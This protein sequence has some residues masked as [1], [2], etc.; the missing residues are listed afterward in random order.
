MH[1]HHR[2]APLSASPLKRL[3]GYLVEAGLLTH[4]QVSVILNDQQATGM[5]FG[6][7]VVAR[8]WLKEQT[9][10]WIVAK[11][12]EPERRLLRQAVSAAHGFHTAPHSYSE[13]NLG[14]TAS[15]PASQNSASKAAIGQSGQERSGTV[16]PSTPP[17]FVRREAPIS[18]PLPSVG[19]ADGDVNWVG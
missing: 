11:V 4:D 2:Q 5:R 18:K 3:G 15:N 19:S 17:K 9:I 12:I 14:T 10:E 13:T 6:D 8:G 7:I 16:S 1:S